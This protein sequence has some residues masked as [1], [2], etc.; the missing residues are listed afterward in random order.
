MSSCRGQMWARSLHLLSSM[1][2]KQHLRCT[3][4]TAVLCS[5]TPRR[6]IRNTSLGSNRTSLITSFSRSPPIRCHLHKWKQVLTLP[7]LLSSR[8]RLQ[9]PRGANISNSLWWCGSNSNRVCIHSVTLQCSSKQLLA[10]TIWLTTPLRKTSS[11]Q[12]EAVWVT[13]WGQPALNRM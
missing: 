10:T 13:R 11:E 5:K 12:E 7:H 6:F 1:V 2:A 3:C 4:K 9:L 8:M